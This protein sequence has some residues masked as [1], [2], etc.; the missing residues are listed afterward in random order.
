MTP[1]SKSNTVSSKTLFLS[2]QLVAKTQAQPQTHDK[3]RQT[4]TRHMAP[5]SMVDPNIMDLKIGVRTFGEEEVETGPLPTAD[6]PIG[7][8]WMSVWVDIGYFLHCLLAW[9]TYSLI[10]FCGSPHPY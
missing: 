4:N 8:G 1:H 7:T 10:S 5:L 2:P 3:D 9:F 6:P